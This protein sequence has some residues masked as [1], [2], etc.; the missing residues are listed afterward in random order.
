MRFKRRLMTTTSRSWIILKTWATHW[1][2]LIISLSLEAIWS[3]TSIRRR[4]TSIVRTCST[5]RTE[6]TAQRCLFARKMTHAPR[7]KNVT[8]LVATALSKKCAKQ[9]G[10][11]SFKMLL[12]WLRA[13]PP[14]S[15]KLWPLR[16]QRKRSLRQEQD[17]LNWDLIWMLPPY[18]LVKRMLVKL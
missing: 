14:L 9:E 12:P 13:T 11:R 6:L 1:L 15:H 4:L 10:L 5:A 16:N 7:L 18:S 17:S 2:C 3:R 8:R